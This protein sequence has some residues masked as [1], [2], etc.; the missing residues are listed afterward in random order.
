M[1][2]EVASD[3]GWRAAEPLKIMPVKEVAEI[4][5]SDEE[6]TSET[7]ER[8]IRTVRVYQRGSEKSNRPRTPGRQNEFR[9]FTCG[10]KGHGWRKCPD[11]VCGNCGQKGHPQ[12]NCWKQ[13]NSNAPKG[14]RKEYPRAYVV[15]QDIMDEEIDCID[16]SE[17]SCYTRGE[18]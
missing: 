18:Y 1:E 8:Q 4:T 7:D 15:G 16:H 14:R 5:M 2:K 10:R 11:N 17:D 12:Q 6:T 3:L 13:G 9:C